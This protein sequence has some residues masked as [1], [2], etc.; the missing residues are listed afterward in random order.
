M[1]WREWLLIGM[2]TEGL[3]RVA[4]WSEA[5]NS[6][7]QLQEDLGTKHSTW[8]KKSARSKK[9]SQLC[10][11]CRKRPGWLEKMKVSESEISPTYTSKAK[12]SL[13]VCMDEDDE[14]WTRL[15]TAAEALCLCLFLCSWRSTG[16]PSI[17]KDD[18]PVKGSLC[19]SLFIAKW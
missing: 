14:F 3:T 10:A 6:W 2:V 13:T 5:E 4:E 11:W 17:G 16:S 9:Q 19:P 1:R 15:S 8:R 18:I 7:N 12:F